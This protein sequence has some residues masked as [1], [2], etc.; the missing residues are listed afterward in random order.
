[1]YGLR[2]LLKTNDKE[3]KFIIYGLQFTE[4]TKAHHLISS[5]DTDW[6]LKRSLNLAWIKIL[7]GYLGPNNL[8]K[9][10]LLWGE[11]VSDQER[12]HDL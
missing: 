12:K 11:P 10:F 6:G 2:T 5:Q 7:A 8:F 9:P 4:I 1:M 3:K